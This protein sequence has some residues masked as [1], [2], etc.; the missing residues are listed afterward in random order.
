MLLRRI[1][2]LKSEEKAEVW[3]KLRN[4]ELYYLL[5]PPHVLRVT[6]EHITHKILVGNIEGM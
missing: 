6:R 2:G 5:I 4:T 3:R 1:P